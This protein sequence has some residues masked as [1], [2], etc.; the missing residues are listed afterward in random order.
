MHSVS[1]PMTL[2]EHAKGVRLRTRRLS[3][4]LLVKQK[5]CRELLIALIG[6]TVV[7]SDVFASALIVV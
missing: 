7:L 2:F 4:I 5:Q 6:E 1:K 3:M